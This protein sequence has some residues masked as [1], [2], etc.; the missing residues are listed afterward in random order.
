MVYGVCIGYIEYI[1]NAHPC[2]INPV[3]SYQFYI[4]AGHTSVA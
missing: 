1:V 2:S 4:L 3:Q